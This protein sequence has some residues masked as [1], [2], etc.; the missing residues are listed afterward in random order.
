MNDNNTSTKCSSKFFAILML[1]FLI[2][3]GLISLGGFVN[4]GLYHFK[5][6]DK[7]VSVKGLAERR[8]KSNLAIWNIGF[9]STGDDLQQVNDK[10][11][12]DQKTIIT[13]L[14]ANGFAANEIEIQ[15]TSVIDQYAAEYPSGNKP[16][17]RYIVNS[18]VKV[19][20]NKVD[21]MRTAS[22]KSSELITKAIIL[23]K[24]YA[25]NPKYM[26][27]TLDE[28]RPSMLEEATKSAKA[29]AEQFAVNSNSHL[30]SI[31]HASQ[32]VFQI[33][34]AD[35][36]SIQQN[37]S[38]QENSLYKT[39]RVVSSIDYFLVGKGGKSN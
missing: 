22:S 12:S 11:L 10:I 39:V 24:D 19:R 37:D 15:P 25:A 6:A 16:E 30:G 23:E 35:S 26:F 17:H 33:Y 7:Y 38:D 2:A 3:I 32:G 9:K 18:A 1:G 5:L 4:N 34:S 29:V 27:T 28:I 21:L 8:V 20:T 14:N 36:S 31:K 13:F